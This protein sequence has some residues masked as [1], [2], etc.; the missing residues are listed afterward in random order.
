MRKFSRLNRIINI[1]E[2]LLIL[3]AILFVSFL[4]AG[5]NDIQGNARV[6]NNAGIVR[7]A[8]QRLVKLEMAK[9]RNDAL[10]TRLDMLLNALKNGGGDDNLKVLP[11]QA[12]ISSLNKQIT[13]WDTLKLEILNTRETS[14]DSTELLRLS[15]K[16]FELAN[17]TVK[18]AER[19]ADDKAAHLIDVEIILIANML[20]LVALLLYKTVHNFLLSKRNKELNE[21]AYTDANTGLPN[22]GK[23]DSVMF[24]QGKLRADTEYAC[25]MFDLNNLKTV[26]DS[27]GHRAGDLLIFNFATIIKNAASED[28][29]VG[30]YGGDEF[31]AVLF[32]TSEDKVIKLL[33]NVNTDVT[34]F[35]ESE[36]D[37]KISYAVGYQ[38]SKGCSDC[39]LHTLLGKAD[40]KMYKDKELKKK[41]LT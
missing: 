7:G 15:E 13:L 12:F 16:Y 2:G 28:V 5:I 19:Y 38:M 25:V 20:L 33:N 4:I 17:R 35:N 41:H 31:I 39:T 3:S 27:L 40:Q 37:I 6:V 24:E 34:R 32:D 8:T 21:M 9:G 1:A 30:R 14:A 22:K 10:I 36:S 11:D 26:N 23:C 29:F 18:E